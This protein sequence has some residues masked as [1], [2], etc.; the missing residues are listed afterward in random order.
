[1][2][3]NLREPM[4]ELTTEEVAIA[5]HMLLG[6]LITALGGVEQAERLRQALREYR[7]Q[8]LEHQVIFDC[9]K[10]IPASRLDLAATLLPERLVRAGFP[11]IDLE[12]FLC[13]DP[14]TEAEAQV[15]CG[16]ILM[17][18]RSGGGPA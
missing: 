5:E 11:D 13:G 6:C 9:L 10:G 1:M 16:N 12:P 7:F 14:L 18:G 17:P 15:L 8:S 4:R 2:D 3:W